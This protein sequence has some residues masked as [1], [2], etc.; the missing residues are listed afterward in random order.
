L[1]YY[2]LETKTG[3]NP[4]GHQMMNGKIES[5]VKS[6]LSSLF[7]PVTLHTSDSNLVLLCITNNSPVSPNFV[8][9]TLA[10]LWHYLPPKVEGRVPPDRPLSLQMPIESG[11]LS[12]TLLIGYKLWVSPSLHHVPLIG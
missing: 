10:E 8:S 1:Q 2:L 7:S 5:E 12:L 11:R 6:S 4:N 9:Y 3:N